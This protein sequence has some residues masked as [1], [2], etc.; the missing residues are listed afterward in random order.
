MVTSWLET[1]KG[2]AGRASSPSVESLFIYHGCMC[3]SSAV[4]GFSPGSYLEHCSREY[5]PGYNLS[6]IISSWLMA[7]YSYGLFWI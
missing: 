7:S 1:G 6:G 2:K 4:P 5:F 3:G